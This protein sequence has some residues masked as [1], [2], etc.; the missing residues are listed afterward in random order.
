VIAAIALPSV[1][2]CGGKAVNSEAKQFVSALNR[3]QQVYYL[4][5]NRFSRD[6]PALGIGI[7]QQTNNF[8]YSTLAT[9]KAVFNYGLARRNYVYRQEQLGPLRWEKR[10]ANRPKSYLG[11]V[12]LAPL[13]AKATPDETTFVAIVCEATVPGI[14]RPA[15]P[16]YQAG[17]L[18]CG[19]GTKEMFNSQKEPR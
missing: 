19:N 14:I 7:S 16:T 1:T 11:A 15:R 17:V 2:D 10:T 18:A 3:A 13:P 9:S 4:D 6:V 8:T 12:F 5:N